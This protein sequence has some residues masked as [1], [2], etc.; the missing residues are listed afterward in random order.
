MRLPTDGSARDGLG[1]RLKAGLAVYTERRVLIILFLGF[2]AGLPLAL[3]GS[4]LLLWMADAGVDLGAIGLY[5][6]VGLPY[7]VK[8]LWAPVV[9]AL[10]V[11]VLSTLL[12]RRRAWLIASQM[13]LM[14]AVVALG[15]LDPLREPLA[16]ALG[17]LA[18]AA[19]SATQDIVIDAFRVE[20][21]RED[22]Q[23]AGMANYVAAYRIGMLASGAGTVVLVAYLETLGIAAGDVWFY[24]YAAMAA[25]VLIGVA[26][27][28]A[29]EEPAEPRSSD[30]AGAVAVLGGDEGLGAA[31]RLWRT[32]Y[33]AFA[34]FLAKPAALTIL[35]FVVLFKLGDAVAGVMTGPFVLA[36][37]FDKATY[38]GIVK[39]VGLAAALAGGFAGGMLARAL[40]LAPALWIAGIVQMV[41]NLAF[42][43]LALAGPSPSILATVIVVENLT[44]GIG[45][46]IF[47]AYLSGLCTSP[48]HTATQFALL[49]ALAAVGRTA[50]SSASGFVAD[51]SGWFAFFAISAAAALPGLALL[52]VLQGRG[53]LATSRQ[54]VLSAT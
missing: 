9:D 18:V 31:S 27:V 51:A 52:A 6:L 25:L 33:R 21:L 20:S 22:E 34:D 44:G 36:I 10:K 37:G 2:S 14:A 32:A 8:F 42:S 4:T 3:S 38:A 7:T 48:A 40:P 23:A 19:A 47:V 17:A 54:P 12:G 29:A 30:P 16:V 49:T 50:L 35:A 11:P 43:W 1:E 15:S 46:V 41:S 13:A 5:A 28:L 24:G 39:G 26:A 45:T 53:H